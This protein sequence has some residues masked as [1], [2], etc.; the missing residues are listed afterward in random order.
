[1]KPLFT[2]LDTVAELYS[3]IFQAENN[4][5]AIR[6]F[7]TSIDLDHKSDFSLWKIGQYDQDKGELQSIDSTLV[8]HGKNLKNKETTQ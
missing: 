1:M 4:E 5:H 2:V 7:E 3:P 8:A 6:M